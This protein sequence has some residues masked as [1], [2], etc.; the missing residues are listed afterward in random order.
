MK[1]GGL[2]LVVV[3]DSKSLCEAL[4][5]TGNIKDRRCR[6]DMAALRQGIEKGDYT[7]AWQS[8]TEMLADP[9]T[10][11]GANPHGLRQVIEEGEGE[12]VFGR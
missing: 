10:K 12:L 2:D 4:S 6:I 3:S 1:E 7:M 8:G 11:K 5:T 9:L